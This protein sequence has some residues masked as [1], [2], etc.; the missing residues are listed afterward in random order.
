VFATLNSLFVLVGMSVVAFAIWAAVGKSRSGLTLAVTVDAAYALLVVGSVLTLVSFAGCCGSIK[1]SRGLLVAYA[2]TV[3]LLLIG[4]SVLV[5]LAFTDNAKSAKAVGDI[6]THMSP[7]DRCDIQ[8]ALQC[9]GF[10]NPADHPAIPCN[11]ARFATGCAAA[12]EHAVDRNIH[13]I[14]GTLIGLGVFQLLLFFAGV[15]LAVKAKTAAAASAPKYTR[16]VANDE[17]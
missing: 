7:T 8:R 6:W 5:G 4:E 17:P 3:L 2:V 14:T 9:T 16:L 10:A 13:T 11:N 12:L 15:F 1:K